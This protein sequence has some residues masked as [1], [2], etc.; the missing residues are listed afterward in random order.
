[1][2]L[3]LVLM[4]SSVLAAAVLR[5]QAANAAEFRLAGGTV[6]EG[7]D[8]YRP[9]AGIEF[10]TGNGLQGELLVWGRT[11]GLV[12]E[13]SVLFAGTRSL[14]LFGNKNLSGLFGVSFLGESTEIAADGTSEASS[15]VSTNIGGVFGVRGTLA[16]WNGVRL[17]ATWESHVFPAGA[18]ALILVTGRKQT[19]TMNAGVSL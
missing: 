10:V 18:S 8:R 17:G 19:L 14:D 12:A 4:T 13:R 11:F 9:A 2:S 5:P 6:E 3:A 15:S 16:Q 1:M 7:D